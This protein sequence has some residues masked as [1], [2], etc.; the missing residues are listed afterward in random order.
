MAGFD[1]HD[2]ALACVAAGLDGGVTTFEDVLAIADT[3]PD[4]PVPQKSTRDWPLSQRL[5]RSGDFKGAAEAVTREAVPG[6]NVSIKA[7][8]LRL[9]DHEL[10]AWDGAPINRLVVPLHHG[11]GDAL[12]YAR[13]LPALRRKARKVSCICSAKLVP[14]TSQIEGI[15][16]LPFAGAAE[17]LQRADAWVRPETLPHLTGEGY[18][19]AAWL[20]GYLPA[21]PQASGV[22]RIGIYLLGRH[23]EQRPRPAA[24]DPGGGTWS[25][26][27]PAGGMAQP[28]GRRPALPRRAGARSAHDGRYGEPDAFARHDRDGG[29][30]RRESGWRSRPAGLRA[31]RS[32]QRLPLGRCRAARRQNAMVSE[33]ESVPAGAGR[34]MAADCAAGARRALTEMGYTRLTRQEGSEL[35]VV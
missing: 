18:G 10:P 9:Q 13:Y 20:A 23:A 32:R 15:E 5:L 7:E 31:D 4:A 1:P 35:L 25:A 22:P 3:L 19:A 28:D 24:L 12:L 21:Q 30:R 26:A 6:A 11:L 34:D 2:I 17:A 29:H 14:L 16:V 33:R 8:R 27:E